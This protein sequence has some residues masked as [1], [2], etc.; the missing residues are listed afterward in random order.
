MPYFQDSNL[1]AVT[2]QLLREA[3]LFG[4]NGSQSG[5]FS[6]LRCGNRSFFG[7][8][9]LSWCW[10][11]RRFIRLWMTRRSMSSRGGFTG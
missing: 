3:A 11:I 1:H 10:E 6:L 5:N 2:C 7:Y 4:S 8:V 9:Y